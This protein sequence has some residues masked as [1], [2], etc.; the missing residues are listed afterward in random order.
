MRKSWL[1]LC[2]KLNAVLNF[3]WPSGCPARYHCFVAAWFLSSWSNIPCWDDPASGVISLKRFSL[4]QLKRL[5]KKATKVS[6]NLPQ[7]SIWW[8][9]LLSRSFT[10]LSQNTG[11][12]IHCSC[13]G[14]LN[15]NP[16]IAVWANFEAPK[17]KGLV[18]L[19]KLP[20]IPCLVLRLCS[21]S[22]S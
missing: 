19:L 3:F 20:A 15:P 16:A 13:A 5:K 22:M 10:C 18:Y 6:D 21:M 8:S 17:A 14:N 1:S 9:D 2:D 11:D 12:E 4:F 7:I